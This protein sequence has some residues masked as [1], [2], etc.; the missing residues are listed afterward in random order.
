MKVS[1][2]KVLLNLDIKFPVELK[3]PED[4]NSKIVPAK[5]AKTYQYEQGFCCWGK[6]D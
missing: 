2:K 6:K 5:N 3:D 1:Q 4:E